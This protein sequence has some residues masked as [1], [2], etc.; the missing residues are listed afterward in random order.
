MGL[1]T[2]GLGAGPNSSQGGGGDGWTAAEKAQIRFRLGMDGAA[3]QPAAGVPNLA[4]VGFA[5]AVSPGGTHVDQDYG[6]VGNLAYVLP[7]NQQAGAGIVHARLVSDYEAGNR[8]ASFVKGSSYTNPDGS[9][10]TPMYL[11]PGAYQFLYFKAGI[12]NAQVKL[13]TVS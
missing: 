5:G 13:A 1:L 7:A 2:G 12:A 11:T 6:G 3:T 9:W 10:A 4:R 8:D